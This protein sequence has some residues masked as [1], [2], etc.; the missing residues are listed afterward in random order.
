VVRRTKVDRKSTITKA[1]IAK[2]IAALLETLGLDVGDQRNGKP[3]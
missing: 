2:F 3:D 1:A